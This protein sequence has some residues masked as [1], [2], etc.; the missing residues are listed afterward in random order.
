MRTKLSDSH[1]GEHI[2]ENNPMW[3][4]FGK[5]HPAYGHRHTEETKAKISKAQKSK[6]YSDEYRKKISESL[7]GEKHPNW[8]KRG[9]MASSWKGGEIFTNEGYKMIYVGRKKYKQEHRIVAEKALGRELKS[10]EVVHHVNGDKSDN[11]NC[12]LLICEKGYHQWLHR[13]MSN[14]YMKEHFEE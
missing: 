5:E 6:I 10:S 3:G 12:N 7:Q 4:K 2:G 8:G 1:K 9:A 13:K 14:L 11:R